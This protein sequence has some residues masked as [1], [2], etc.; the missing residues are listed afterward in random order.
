MAK[1]T[2]TVSAEKMMAAVYNGYIVAS[3]STL[4]EYLRLKASV[5]GGS[6]NI[7]VS[8]N[9]REGGAY[10]TLFGKD[11][12]NLRI[13]LGGGL[14]KKIT[15][16]PNTF[17]EKS[18]IKPY[19]SETVIAVMALFYHEMGHDLFTD[20]WD[21]SIQNY[22]KPQFRNLFHQI[23]NILE[24]AVIEAAISRHC[25]KYYFYDVQPKELFRWNI[26]KLFEPQAETYEDDGK[27]TGFLNYLLLM[28][29]CGR[30]K[31]KGSCIVFNKYE[32]EIL[33]HIKGFLTEQDATK[34]IHKAIKFGEWI[35]DNIPE[36]DWSETPAPEEITAGKFG[37]TG[38][39]GGSPMPTGAKASDGDSITKGGSGA[40]DDDSEGDGDKED[41]EDEEKG[42]SAPGSDSKE[43]GPEE[44]ESGED[45]ESSG[46]EDRPPLEENE[47]D[48]E[49]IDEVFND[50]VHNGDDHEWIVA[51][52]DVTYD[53]K[54][55]DILDQQ[56]EEFG[57]C[58]NDVTKF[59]KLFKGRIAP[60]ET[61][62][63][64]SGRFDVR[65]AI[66]SK[67]AGVPDVKLFKQKHERGK[68]VDLCVSLLCDNSGSMCG[69]KSVLCSRAALVLAQACDWANIPFECNAFT[70]TSDSYDGTS[71][72]IREK[73]FE[74]PFNEAK[75]FFALNDT[76]LQKYIRKEN[77]F[78]T[79]Q[80]NW[81]E[82]NL[83]YIWQS[84]KKVNHKKKLLIVLCDGATCGST[85]DLKDIVRKIELEDNIF[86]L[87][88]GIMCNTVADIYPHYRLFNSEKELNEELAPFLIDVIGSHAI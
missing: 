39:G 4:R 12:K 3:G 88:I 27:I 80:G 41:P 29:R 22:E 82:V 42:G 18:K 2:K 33:D 17:D 26:K 49:I 30:P 75:P 81:E 70:R 76:T 67:M 38:K 48:E 66:N 72:T 47:G 21:R 36:F 57:D 35:V 63:F 31:I 56:I 28:L 32:K 7:A 37:G 55:I 6:R 15:S 83:Y 84:L 54:V 14:V 8:F 61:T 87:G 51:K 78:P 40:A 77:R 16:M 1:K 50:F 64:T 74:D 73:G 65:R 25:K 85:N 5:M 23:F 52:D 13:M 45:S 43:E 86:V 71:I 19:I 68:A 58:I 62:G 10:T 59:L 44:E 24:D 11:G 79:F 60:R 69:E 53:N 9:A 20:M 34:R 46:G